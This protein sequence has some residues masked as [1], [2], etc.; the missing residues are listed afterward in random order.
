MISRSRLEG[1]EIYVL[2]GYYA[3]S[4]GN[5]LPTF[6]DKQTVPSSRVENPVRSYHCTLRN[7][8]KKSKYFTF[9]FNLP[10]TS[11]FLSHFLHAIYIIS[12]FNLVLCYSYWPKCSKGFVTFVDH[13]CVSFVL[14]G[15]DKSVN[16]I[17]LC[18]HPLHALCPYIKYLAWRRFTITETCCQ[19]CIND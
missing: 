16:G 2:L 9:H 8:P 13:L 12:K 1:D 18:V 7:N 6:R 14:K 5:F 3:A 10:F 11:C 17:P 4:S 19:P 15:Q